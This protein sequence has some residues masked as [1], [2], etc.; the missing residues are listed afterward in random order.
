M[1]LTMSRC[2]S[3]VPPPPLPEPLHWSTEVVSWSDGVVVVVQVS[4]ALAA[5]WHSLT[6]DGGTGLAGGEVEVV[7]DG[8][9]ACHRLAAD[10]VGAV[11]LVHGGA[12]AA[13]AAII[14]VGI[15]PRGC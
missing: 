5:P 4:A 13:A 12:G 6:V 15:A 11:A 7:G 8:D 9:V 3:T 1:L 10:V 14:T 2:R